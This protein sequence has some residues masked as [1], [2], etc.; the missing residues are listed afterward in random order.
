MAFDPNAAAT[1]DGIY[2]L[3]HTPEEARVV[4]VPVPWDATCSYGAGA[5]GGPEA[6]LQASRQVDLL[7]RETGRPYEGGI[8][9]LPSPEPVA[10]WN[11]NARALAEPV[12]RAGGPDG[13]PGM[14]QAVEAVNALGAEMNGWVE[15]TTRAWLDR[16]KL[17]GVV[18][19]DHSVPFGFLRELAGRHPGLG[20]LH[21]DA[22]ADLRTAYEGFTWSHASIMANVLREIPGVAR[23]IQVG[24]RDYGPEEEA[25]IL[26]NPDRVRTFFDPDLKHRLYAG[27]PWLEITREIV[28]SLPE[29]VYLSFDID[30]LDP[31][32]CPGTGTPVPGGLSF[33]ETTALL[34]T[35][36]ESGRRIV[37]FDLCEVAP[38]AGGRSEWDGNVGARL[39]YKMIGFALRTEG[40]RPSG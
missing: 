23:L 40:A 25:R 7:D 1:G 9:M 26:E 5:S 34:R 13:T 19:G 35:L 16:G 10:T 31:V 17:V 33:T 12:I 6:I 14:A 3:P 15:A 36:A 39:L 20:I 24:I 21:L 2:G 38:D 4:L 11:G 8:A 30:G 27:E 18:G 22:H 29:T 32:L 37:G 28:G